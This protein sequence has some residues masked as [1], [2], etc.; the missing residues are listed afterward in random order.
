MHFL[1]LLP[2]SGTGGLLSA[3]PTGQERAGRAAGPSALADSGV[4]NPRDRESGENLGHPQ[5]WN[6]GLGWGLTAYCSLCSLRGQPRRLSLHSLILAPGD[7][8]GG[9]MPRSPAKAPGAIEAEA[10]WGIQKSLASVSVAP[11]SLA[12]PALPLMTCV[13]STALRTGCILSPLGG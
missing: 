7:I 4:R 13:H 6:P 10:R 11:S 8:S 3:V 2:A 12:F 1:P 5:W 9:E